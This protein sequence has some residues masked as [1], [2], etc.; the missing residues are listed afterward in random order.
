MWL[1]GNQGMGHVPSDLPG[2]DLRAW[3]MWS[4]VIVYRF[5]TRP[6]EVV[7]VLGAAQA[8]ERQ[9]FGRLERE[10]G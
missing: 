7:R 3:S 10:G 1:A 8:F 5:G 9:D 6:L 4:F 2:P